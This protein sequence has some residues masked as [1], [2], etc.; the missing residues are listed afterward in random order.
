MSDAAPR[1]NRDR[2]LDAVGSI[3]VKLAL[4]VIASIVAAAVVS[5]LGRRAGV[6]S[7]VSVP[8]TMV[9]ALAVTWW[10]ARG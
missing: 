8:V 1:L 7:L 2:P 5:A 9:A 6:P 3:K 10:L 4:L